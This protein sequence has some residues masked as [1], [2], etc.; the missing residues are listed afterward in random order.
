MIRFSYAFVA[1]V[2]ILIMLIL[3]LSRPSHAASFP[4]SPPPTAI[5]GTWHANIIC[6]DVVTQSNPATTAVTLDILQKQPDGTWDWLGNAPVCVAAAGCPNA[7]TGYVQPDGN[8]AFK[9]EF[10]YMDVNSSAVTYRDPSGQLYSQT[11]ISLMNLRQGHLVTDWISPA[12]TFLDALWASI[13]GG[14][15]SGPPF[16]TTAAAAAWLQTQMTPY[17]L[18]TAGHVV[19]K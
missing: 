4:Y 1:I 12:N 5:C 7:S 2:T 10:W 8:W 6:M 3:G 14:G 15:T 18:N 11:A 19:P 17:M 16:A 13:G 9:S